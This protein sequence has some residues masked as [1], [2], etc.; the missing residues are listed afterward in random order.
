MAT[1]KDTTPSRIDTNTP[2][3]ELDVKY[4]GLPRVDDRIQNELTN[5]DVV[6]NFPKTKNDAGTEQVIIN[7]D[8][9]IQGLEATDQPTATT[10]EA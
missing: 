10:T 4:E 7:A 2:F 9:S 3:E 8:G 6:A 1:A 5:D